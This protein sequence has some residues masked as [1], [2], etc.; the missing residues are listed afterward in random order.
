MS[1]DA[2]LAA[3]C[4]RI[5]SLIA[6]ERELFTAPWQAQL[7]SLRRAQSCG[8]CSNLASNNTALSRAANSKRCNGRAGLFKRS[9]SGR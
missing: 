1:S 9:A 2:Q 3:S 4:W 7:G 5:L 6:L 8:A